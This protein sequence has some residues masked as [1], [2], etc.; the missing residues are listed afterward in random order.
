MNLWGRP[1]APTNA[2]GVS[3]QLTDSQGSSHGLAG[4]TTPV[5]LSCQLT[6]SWHAVQ[7]EFS[8]AVLR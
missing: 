5:A 2:T 3:H 8:E 7:V 4:Q 6:L 1:D